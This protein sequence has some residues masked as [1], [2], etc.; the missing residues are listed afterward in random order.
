MS[1]SGQIFKAQ[2]HWLAAIFFVVVGIVALAAAPPPFV[3]QVCANGEN[4]DENPCPAGL[5]CCEG[6]CQE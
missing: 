6:V 2:S 3:Q 5:T 1:N 4:C